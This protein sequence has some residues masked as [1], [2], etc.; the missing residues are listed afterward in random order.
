MSTRSDASRRVP[1]PPRGRRRPV[2]GDLAGRLRAAREAEAGGGGSLLRLSGEVILLLK[3][4][5]VD[6]R[7]PRDAKVTAG[8]AA[9]YL[10]SPLDIIPDW[11]P[12][13]GQL[14]DLVVI[15]AAFRRLLGAA[16]YDTIYDVWRGSDE[17][18]A[19]VLTLAGIQ[20]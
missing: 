1:G 20:D 19:L 6:P 4:L 11:V 2:R 18:L 15:A 14:D 5:A 13:L 10:V 3:D 16:G 9:A 7:V 17:G 8:A 12:V